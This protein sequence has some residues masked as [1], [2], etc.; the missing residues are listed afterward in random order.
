MPAVAKNNHH[1]HRRVIEFRL[2]ATAVPK[3]LQTFWIKTYGKTKKVRPSVT[4]LEA[5]MI[6]SACLPDGI[7]GSKWE[8]LT[9][10]ETHVL[11]IT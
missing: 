8:S 2:A 1:L 3:K 5:I 9:Q 6:E 10:R 11:G 7:I 4:H